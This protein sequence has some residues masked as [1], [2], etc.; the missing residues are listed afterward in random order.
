MNFH[1]NPLKIFFSYYKPH[2]KLF[3][4]DM[5][6]AFMIAAIDV[7]FPM[8]SRYALDILI[9]N[10][11]LR[12]F[13][14]FI[15]ILGGGY[16]LRWLCNW[17]V[18]YW[19][20]IFGNRIEQDMRRDVFSHLEKL[21]FSFYDTN[22]TGKIMARATTDLFEITELAHHGP[23]DFFIAILTIFGSFFLLLKIRW[24]LAIIVIISMPIILFIVIFSRRNLSKTSKKVKET[25]AEINANL[26]SSISGIRVTK[27]FVNEEL[28]NKNFDAMNKKYSH[29]KRIR[30]K[31]MAFFHSNIELCNN[32]LSLLVLAAGGYFIMKGKMTLP[33]LVAANLFIA[34]F[35]API[36]K[37][38]NFVEQ[39]STGMA[40]FSRF[41]EIMQT[42]PEEP[43]SPDAV[44][45]LASRGNIS[46]EHVNF[47]YANNIQ[48][49]S[50]INFTVKSGEKFAL[51][52]SSGGGKSTICNLIPRFYEISE[53][54]ILLD[55]I[56]IKKIKRNSLRNQ[57]GIVQQDVFLFAG[58]VRE[59]IAYAKPNATEQEI[60]LAA[61]RAEIH[62]DIMNMPDG[63]ETI[64][65][66]RG[67]KLSGGQKQRISI[68]RCFL[69]NPPI[70][71]L[72]EATSALDTATEIKIQKAF[73][74]LSK[75]RTTIVIAHRLSTIK[76]ADK[77]AVINHK[78]ICETGTHS[79]LIAK[80]GEYY[81]LC[82]AQN[83]II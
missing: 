10:G 53:G 73:D 82:Q 62:D 40:G 81:K 18:N 46:F 57:I 54:Q 12:I 20:H 39:F 71:I 48:V 30:F 15:I 22:R 70:L 55:G 51:V 44:E 78:T 29:A 79:D 11:N 80:Q 59:N 1:E 69:K 26:E 56:N 9:P 50:D 32:L 72:D 6:C 19:G 65:G 45:I 63:Y 24:E 52:G 7:A 35:T 75:G 37:L 38:T 14:F 3:I 61:K 27:G 8:F 2:L 60:I 33:D 41:L 42:E 25:T 43:D 83:G 4:A 49:L 77:I 13:T 34:S 28:E 58:S 23:E 64:V 21:P 68:A 36:R 16:F 74:E 76:N 5:I 66:E 17:F 31:Y 47:S 67:I